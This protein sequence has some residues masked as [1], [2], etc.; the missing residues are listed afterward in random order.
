MDQYDNNHYKFQRTIRCGNDVGAWP[1]RTSL[2][3]REEN[4]NAGAADWIGVVLVIMTIITVVG[5][6]I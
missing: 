2:S 4:H 3:F 6:F 1:V 5:T